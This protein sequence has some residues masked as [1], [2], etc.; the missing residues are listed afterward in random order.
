MSL[1]ANVT[2]E[3]P[4][5]PSRVVLYAP[6]KA[7][8]TSFG[9]H[10]PDPIFLMTAGETG[11]L[12]LIESG[13]V[14]PTAHFPDDFMNWAGLTAAVTAL[15]VEKHSYKTLVLDTGNGAEQMLLAHAC[16]QNFGGD[17]AEFN[18][19]GRGLA[20]AVP[21]WAEFLKQLDD[22]RTRRR[23]SVL[24]LHHSRVK[25]FQNPAGKDWD[26][27]KPEA[28]DKLWSLTHKW[29]DVIAFYGSRVKVDRDDKAVGAEQRFLRCAP[30]AAIVAGNRYGMPDEVTAP[31]GAANL[32]NA[33]AKAL[34][35]AK[36]KA[37]QTAPPPANGTATQPPPAASAA[38]P[39]LPVSQGQPPAAESSPAPAR[40][41][42]DRATELLAL[43]KACGWTWPEGYAAWADH[44]CTE[45]D[46]EML[47]EGD[48]NGPP[49]PTAL[50]A[51]QAEE[52]AVFLQAVKRQRAAAAVA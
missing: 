39:N 17:W 10:A 47:P 42:G 33:F 26:Q 50:N 31:P 49:K 27:W 22:L 28:V 38:P 45:G 30:S 32:W 20:V 40:T 36:T 15:T 1:L 35:A 48:E 16:E 7:G 12:S 25:A 34:V 23:M 52:M 24:F 18:S 3:A 14:P 43:C 51:A 13:Q 5:L 46:P 6:E 8:K 44:V 9:C 2:K 37:R 41:N 21:R 29:A 4:Q 11:L 19:Y